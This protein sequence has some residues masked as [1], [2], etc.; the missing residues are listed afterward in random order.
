MTARDFEN[1]KSPQIL[2]SSSSQG[3]GQ[4]GSSSRERE[5]DEGQKRRPPTAAAAVVRRISSLG[6]LMVS[7]YH[8]ESQWT[9]SGTDPYG[10]SCL[11]SQGTV[12]ITHHGDMHATNPITPLPLPD[13]ASGG[14]ETV[15]SEE[16]K[17]S[18]HT[19]LISSLYEIQIKTP[20]DDGG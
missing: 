1:P 9:E 2:L 8:D 3:Q 12:D 19:K 15:T 14:G 6:Q 18:F 20:Q 7:R 11:D 10:L 17:E 13:F 5:G 16:R 4:G